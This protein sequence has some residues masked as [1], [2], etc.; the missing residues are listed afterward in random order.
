M[1]SPKRPSAA[2]A[3]RP[4]LSDGFLRRLFSIVAMGEGWNGGREKRIEPATAAA[5]VRLASA[6]LAFAPE[7]AVGP[8]PDGSVLLEWQLEPKLAMEAYV[9]GDAGGFEV[10]VS[11][12]HGVTETSCETSDDVLKQLATLLRDR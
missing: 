7:P 2:D 10:V 5:A 12:D 3:Q 11:D 9:G 4:I 8:S 6:S 1:A